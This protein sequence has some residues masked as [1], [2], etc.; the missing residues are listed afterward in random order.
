LAPRPH[1][2]DQEELVVRATRGEGGGGK[3]D[4]LGM[5]ADLLPAQQIAIKATRAL[6]VADV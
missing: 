3:A 1:R 5:S 2:P 6:E 4:L